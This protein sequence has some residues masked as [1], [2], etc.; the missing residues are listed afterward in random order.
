MNSIEPTRGSA[1]ELT[2]LLSAVYAIFHAVEQ[3]EQ[4]CA[5]LIDSNDARLMQ[6][7]A[8]LTKAQELAPFGEK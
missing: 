2:N 8:D 5:D 1:S 3:L 4:V 7:R 6:A